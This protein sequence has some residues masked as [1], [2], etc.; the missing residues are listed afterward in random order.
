MTA[1][2]TSPALDI[3]E[4]ARRRKAT[5]S[6]ASIAADYG[7][8]RERIRQLLVAEYG[9]TWSDEL[10]A[11][12]ASE[13]EKTLASWRMQ[14]LDLMEAGEEVTR[15]EVVGGCPTPVNTVEDVL[16]EFA[17]AV[18]FPQ[19]AHAKYSDAEIFASMQR[20]WAK[21]VKPEPLTREG[22]D[23]ARDASKDVSGARIS[24]RMAWS[25]ACAKAEVPTVPTRREDYDRLATETATEWVA[26]FLAH[27]VTT[28]IRG[29]ASE[30]DAWAREVG[31]PSM[32]SVRAVMRSWNIA[33]ASAVPRVLTWQR[34]GMRKRYPMPSN[35]GTSQYDKSE[36]EEW[37]RRRA[38]SPSMPMREFA[39]TLGVAES[40]VRYHLEP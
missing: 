25:E 14:M 37:R 28:G 27:A 4:I 32:G 26:A 23:A 15:D 35:S 39:E 1:T 11:T 18:S 29:S 5:E 38:K 9:T 31:G 8:T 10:S 19:K 20:V 36:V 2:T 16:G 3:E 17:W 6:M 7:V 30:Y 40:T 33:R 12:A 24:Q 22:Y 13:R 34:A 21:H